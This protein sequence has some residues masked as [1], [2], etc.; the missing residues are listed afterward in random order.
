[1]ISI[2]MPVYNAGKYLK[3]SIPDI[4]NQT[5]IEFELICVDDG[6]TD[7]SREIL[8]YY[9]QKDKRIKII[10]Q[11]NK[12][13]GAA[14]NVGLEECLGEYVLFWDSDDRYEPNAIEKALN[15]AIKTG[16]D[17]IVFNADCYETDSGLVFGQQWLMEEMLPD[18]EVFSYIDIPDQIFLFTPACV[19][20][21]L[22]KRTFLEGIGLK[23]QETPYMNDVMFEQV[24]IVRASSISIEKSVLV[25]YRRGVS[26]SVSNYEN[27]SRN[28]H[29]AF[30][31]IRKTKDCLCK[32]DVYK[33]V[34]KSYANHSLGVIVSQ[35]KMINSKTYPLFE[36]ELASGICDEIGINK[37]K[38]VE[39]EWSGGR[40]TAEIL[41]SSSFDGILSHIIFLSRYDNSCEIKTFMKYPHL[42][43]NCI[44]RLNGV[45]ENDRILLYGAGYK[46]KRIYGLMRMTGKY[47]FAGFV[48]SKADGNI[49]IDGNL[50]HAP[51]QISDLYYDYILITVED[52]YHMKEIRNYLLSIG[53]SEKII[54]W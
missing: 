8:D 32:L 12:G 39:I 44:F 24:S 7:Y 33:D 3:E 48:D 13:A 22:Y 27:K 2:I 38:N 18:K 17:I 10:S 53:V 54:I 26:G 43:Y 40:Q 14:R 4:L 42:E 35:L 37:L 36:K 29:I 19:W 23:F 45:N 34:W 31:V 1:M 6:S 21:K 15:R 51:S 28:P 47:R 41:S 16:S 9:A 5:Y 46:G 52:Y 50:I 20:N 25:H 30:D 49:Q 11:K